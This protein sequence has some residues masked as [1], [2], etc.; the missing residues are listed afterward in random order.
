M[1]K[2][3]RKTF[4]F[5]PSE[6]TECGLLKNPKIQ[7]SNTTDFYLLGYKIPESNNNHNHNDHHYSNNNEVVLILSFFNSFTGK[8]E[9]CPYC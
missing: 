2:T 3:K 7:Y 9:K 1:D 6:L 4:M 5:I 8:N